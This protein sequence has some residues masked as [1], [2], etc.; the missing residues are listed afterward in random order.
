MVSIFITLLF[1]IYCLQLLDVSLGWISKLRCCTVRFSRLVV[2]C[3]RRSRQR[4]GLL[5]AV[6][7]SKDT[8]TSE[9]TAVSV[10]YQQTSCEVLRWAKSTGCITKIHCSSSNH[11]LCHPT[12]WRSISCQY[13]AGIDS[14]FHVNVSCT[15]W[16]FSSCEY[17]F[18]KRPRWLLWLQLTSAALRC[19]G[20]AS[21]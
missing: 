14:I 13:T 8:A 2:F 17:V 6:A 15:S 11:C 10:L 20:V 9:A 19:A 12:S 1:I 16:I 4:V 3:A 5:T 21:Q 18:V 7:G